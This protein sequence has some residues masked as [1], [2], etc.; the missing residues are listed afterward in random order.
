MKRFALVFLALVL[1]S[2]PAL[3]VD[4]DSMSYDELLEL[5]QAVEAKMREMPEWGGVLVPEG[6]YT[7]GTDIPAGKYTYSTL[8]NRVDTY[9]FSTEEEVLLAVTGN[10]SGYL[11]CYVARVDKEPF[12]IDFAEN[13]YIN[14][15][16]GTAL[17][18]PYTGLGF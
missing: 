17:L 2:S 11:F 1:V 16:G 14:V 9:V 12:N 10:R 3:A 7:V 5:S 4:L 8:S 15:N 13:T 18:K 6:V